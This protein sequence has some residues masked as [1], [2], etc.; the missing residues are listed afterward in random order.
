VKLRT[1]VAN[2]HGAPCGLGCEREIRQGDDIVKIDD[3][4]CHAECAE[5]DGHDVENPAEVSP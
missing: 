1:Y 4:W 2:F 3:E 5:D